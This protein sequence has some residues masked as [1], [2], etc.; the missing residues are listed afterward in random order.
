MLDFSQAPF[1]VIWE[2]TQACDLACKHCRASARPERDPDELTH[3]ESRRLLRQ[4]RDF[5]D[6]LMVFTGGDPL[7]RPDLFA[8]LEESV[9]LGLRTT[10]TPSATPLLT[11]DAVTRI[12]NCGVSRMAVS[13]DGA[14][15]ETHDSFRQVAGSF[16][17]TMSALRQAARVGLET[18]INTTVTRYNR[19]SLGRI[20]KLVGEEGARL[21][22]VF[23]LVVTGRAALADDLS[24][25]EYERVFEFLYQT[26]ITAPYMIKTTEAQH[27]RRYVAQQRRSAR[28]LSNVNDGRGFLFV[29]H[30]GEIFP[31][32]FLEVSAGN[33]KRTTVQEAYRNSGV[34]R[35]LRD[36]DALGGKCGLC[37]Y[38]NLCGGSRSRAFA[39]TG[40]YLASDPRCSYQPAPTAACTPSAHTHAPLD[41]AS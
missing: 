29:S 12:R 7:K 25:E 31:S 24:A 41:K 14:D 32:G 30:T 4:I 37:D 13:L 8:L 36:S 22:S 18:Q 16:E 17:R 3:E 10:V 39:L 6:P 27:Y 33:V 34:F 20:A 5:G 19:D 21:W 38:R 9:K 40:D 2:T 1:L 23:F 15:A 35:V 26:S 11:D 28:G